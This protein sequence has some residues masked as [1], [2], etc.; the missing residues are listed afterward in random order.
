M[1]LDPALVGHETARQNYTISA[2]D[3]VAFA[4]AIGDHN[5]LFRDAGAARAAG[6]TAPLATP[7]FATRFRVPAGEIGLDFTRS[8]VLHGE[9]EYEYARPLLAGD[10]V[11]VWH[12]L[13]TLRQSSRGDGMAILTLETLGETT[14]GEHI[15]TG[16]ATV[17]VREGAPGQAS[18]ERAGRAG[19]TPEGAPTGPLEKHVTQTQI[20]AYA[21]VS[22]DHNPIHIDPEA[23]RAVGLE[24]TIAHG[25]LSM[26]FLGQLVT[27]WSRDLSAA[28][29]GSSGWLAR[30]Q[31]RFQAMVRPEDTLTCRGVLV[32]GSEAGRQS[33]QL[34]AEN[35]RGERVTSGEAEVAGVLA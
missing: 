9:Q 31:V 3:I 26:A 22:G 13:A 7:T 10:E 20:N 28:A 27:D 29:P 11:V 17:I 6:F 1:P 8:Q 34:W 33:L 18:A 35:Q 19:R 15:F 14:A 4:D 21:E 2:A 16:R 30:L 25:M 12:R 23:A 32:A 24:G 5:P